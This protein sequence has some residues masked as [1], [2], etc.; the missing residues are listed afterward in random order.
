MCIFL[1]KVSLFLFP[2]TLH[3][4]I[5]TNRD[6]IPLKLFSTFCGQSSK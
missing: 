4:V 1:G 6:L 5:P 3:G 2:R